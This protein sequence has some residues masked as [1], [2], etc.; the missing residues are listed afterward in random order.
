LPLEPSLYSLPLSTSDLI[1]I[2]LT[3][4]RHLSLVLL[5]LGFSV[6]MRV[7][8]ELHLKF[9]II[10]C[11]HQQP[12]RLI[13][14]IRHIIMSQTD[15]LIILNVT[16]IMKSRRLQ[17]A[18]SS[19]DSRRNTESACNSAG[20]AGETTRIQSF[21][22]VIPELFARPLLS[23]DCVVRDGAHNIL[24]SLRVATL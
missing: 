19:R 4:I 12:I 13:M 23:L 21:H 2:R 18:G 22:R 20:W 10:S 1:D 7:G 17:K 5:I 16:D 24:Q 9:D 15:M 14:M 8:L 11:H 6:E 3:A